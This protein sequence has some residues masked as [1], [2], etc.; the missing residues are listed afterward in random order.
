MASKLEKIIVRIIIAIPVIF[1]AGILFCILYNT[2]YIYTTNPDYFEK[3]DCINSYTYKQS[4][5][6]FNTFEQ[7]IEEIIAPYGFTLEFKEED[8][9]QWGPS[10]SPNTLP[11]LRYNAKRY[12]TIKISDNDVI[13]VTLANREGKESIEI[14]YYITTDDYEKD[15]FS[16]SVLDIMSAIF[17]K[18]CVREFY[19]PNVRSAKESALASDKEYDDYYMEYKRLPILK[20]YYGAL[21]SYYTSNAGYELGK[22]DNGEYIE[23]YNVWCYTRY[24]TDFSR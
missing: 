22:T 6:H 3:G 15:N 4:F 7:E 12:Y 5:Q 2:I 11:P 24:A 16:Q 14:S 18:V 20:C 9:W 21:D 23:H 13:D 10:N 19:M 1:I 17:E 8:I